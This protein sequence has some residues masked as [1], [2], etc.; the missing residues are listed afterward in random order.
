MTLNY[1]TSGAWGSGLGRAL[2]ASEVDTNFWTHDQAI[3][4][5]EALP[6]G[7]SISSI[8]QTSPNQITITLTDGRTYVFTL[9][10]V[11]LKWR[12]EWAPSTYYN[13]NDIISVASL[14]SVYVVL[15]GHTSAA[16]FSPGANNGAGQMYYQLLL[17]VPNVLPTGGAQGAILA[18][19]TATDYDVGWQ[20]IVPRGGATATALFKNSATDFDTL[21]RSVNF[22][23]MAGSLAPSQLRLPLNVVLTPAAGI[24]TL[25][26]GAANIF[27]ITP[28]ANTIINATSAPVDARVV[29]F[30]VASTAASYNISFGTPFRPNGVLATGTAAGTWNVCFAG[31]GNFL[32]ELSRLGPL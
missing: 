31:D 32:Y 28:T 10:A 5:L 4:A 17:A 27:N 9:P 2:V 16:T 12:G 29:V 1:R 25:D 7:V 30:I 24:A 8:T 22:S 11:T 15:A 13:A 20:V 19:T 14:Q 21:W 6:L 3:T 18:K 23:D 26:P